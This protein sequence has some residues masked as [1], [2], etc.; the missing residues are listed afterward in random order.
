VPSC[1][2]AEVN[3]QN[4]DK[5]G[6]IKVCRKETLTRCSANILHC[7]AGLK[8]LRPSFPGLGR[9]LPAFNI[10]NQYAECE[11]GSSASRQNTMATLVNGR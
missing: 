4:E 11:M 10:I 2:T 1:H 6:F 3:T 7:E 5:R 9:S 8:N